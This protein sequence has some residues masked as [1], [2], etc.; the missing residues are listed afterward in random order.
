MRPRGVIPPS[1]ASRS[2]F[3]EIAKQI[4]AVNLARSVHIDFQRCD[5][6]MD[7]PDRMQTE[8]QLCKIAT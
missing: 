2:L 8:P 3:K 5:N 1:G 4:A 7:R 6:A